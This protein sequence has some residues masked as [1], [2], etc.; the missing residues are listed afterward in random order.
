[1]SCH[2][3]E[4]IAKPELGYMHFQLTVCDQTDL[5]YTHNDLGTAIPNNATAMSCE[6][7]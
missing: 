2:T 1:M 3:D 7:R 5:P 4:S 6:L